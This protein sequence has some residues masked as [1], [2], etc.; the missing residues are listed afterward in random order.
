MTFSPGQRVR[1]VHT[2]DPY[3]KLVSGDIGTVNH[4]DDAG[5]VHVN[6]DS[7]STLGMCVADFED[8]DVIVVIA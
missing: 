1:L 6:W 7:G 4:I 8:P 2:N 5:T 3:T